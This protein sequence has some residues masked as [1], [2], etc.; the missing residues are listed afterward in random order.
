MALVQLPVG[1]PVRVKPGKYKQG[2]LTLR[3][4]PLKPC[5]HILQAFAGPAEASFCQ[6]QSLLDM[7][8][9]VSRPAAVSGP[10]ASRPLVPYFGKHDPALK[11]S[12]G[13]KKFVRYSARTPEALSSFE[14]SLLLTLYPVLQQDSA[15]RQRTHTQGSWR[16]LISRSGCTFQPCCKSTLV[17]RQAAQQ[18]L[19]FLYDV[20]EP[21]RRTP[22]QPGLPG[23]C[24]TNL[25]LR[26]ALL[27]FSSAS[28][29]FGYYSC[30][31]LTLF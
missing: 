6:G 11:P 10:V 14:A 19:G 15:A 4:C 27:T 26:L 2:Q 1:V 20:P 7:L 5:W 24:Q 8:V 3:T 18:G 21:R 22:A 16:T 13:G 12:V 17:D 30:S 31:S 9:R 23:P 28:F 29:F 25:Y